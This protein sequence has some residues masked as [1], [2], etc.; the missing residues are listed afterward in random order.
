MST[1]DIEI[2]TAPVLRTSLK[3]MGL[4][5]YGSREVM[6]QRLI[7]G[8]EKKKP[9][10]KPKSTGPLAKSIAKP[11]TSGVTT[12][13]KASPMFDAGELKFFA[14]ERPRL[15][16]LGITDPIAQNA[17][18]KRRYTELKKVTS[19]PL[20]LLSTGGKAKAPPAKKP[21]NTSDGV[22]PFD[23]M[24]SASQLKQLNLV[25]V[26]VE[27][28]ASGKIIYN[29]K[30]KSKNPGKCTGA[31]CE[32]D[33]DNSDDDDSGS[34]SDGGDSAMDECEDIVTDR[35]K[36][37]PKELL[38]AACKHHGVEVSGS[39]KVLAERVAEQL[40]NET[41]NENDDDDE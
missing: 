4:P 6:Y 23:N 27:P 17:E 19:S 10:P 7:N 2:P 21:S 3:A 31:E 40:C 26:N 16:A 24:L 38:K 29:Y 13:T 32:D 8:G 18:L 28:D 34:D 37:W 33:S 1:T 25:L 14:D 36:E 5:V 15:I 39:K 41:D 11:K 30:N 9:G 20:G 35:L 12:H 22:I